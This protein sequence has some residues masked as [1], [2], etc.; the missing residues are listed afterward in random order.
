MSTHMKVLRWTRWTEPYDGTVL[1]P[2]FTPFPSADGCGSRWHKYVCTRGE[3]HTGRHAAGD[4]GVIVA[5]WPEPVYDVEQDDWRI[6]ATY[7]T[8]DNLEIYRGDQLYRTISYPTYKIWNI[9]AHLDDVIAQL[10]AEYATE[11]R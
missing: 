7:A 2:D 4:G 9:P 5:V 8:R 3:N 1:P 6:T 11:G 10:N